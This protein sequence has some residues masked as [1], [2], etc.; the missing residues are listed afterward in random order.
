MFTF[1]GGYDIIAASRIWSILYMFLCRFE[2]PEELPAEWILKWEKKL[3]KKI[4]VKLHDPNPSYD[5]IPRKE[6][7]TNRNHELVQRLLD[8]VVADW[9]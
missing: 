6:E 7:I 3:N 8:A 4:P 2:I 1:G 9:L 5:P